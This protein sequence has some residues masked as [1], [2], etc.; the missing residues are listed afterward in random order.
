[1]TDRDRA[2]RRTRLASARLYLCAP[3]TRP[4]HDLLGFLGAVA[5]AG[6]DLLQLRDKEASTDR[7]R[8]A[9]TAFRA[10][11]A[12]EEALFIVNDDPELAG[13]VDA[14]G[15]HVGQEDGSVEAA[16]AI[17]GED[18]IVG[19][20]THSIEQIDEA[21]ETDADYLGVGPVNPTPTKEGRAG[22]GLE[23]VRHAAAVADRPFFVTGGMSLDTVDPVLEAG[24]HGVVVVRALT[25]AEEPAR[26]AGHLAK[27][28]ERAG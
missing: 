10:V 18:R 14:D 23:P 27:R 4:D 20:S 6:V 12:A 1:M 9:A 5:G 3:A 11:A 7:Q 2:W 8:R 15:V 21:L 13:E 28:I 24:A 16:R 25:E 22:I 26:V 17:V 19:R